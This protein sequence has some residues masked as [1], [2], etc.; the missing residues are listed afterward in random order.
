MS[1]L[2]VGDNLLCNGKENVTLVSWLNSTEAAEIVPSITYASGTKKICDE[3]KE[4]FDK[5]DLIRIYQL[6]MIL[7]S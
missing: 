3:F 5:D 1:K 2:H 6:S 4:K 7:Q